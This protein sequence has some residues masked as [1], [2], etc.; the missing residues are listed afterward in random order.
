MNSFVKT[1]DSYGKNFVSLFTAAVELFFLSYFSVKS[2]MLNKA[3]NFRSIISVL[4]AQVYFTGVQ[5]LPL[6]SILA[7]ATGVIFL[8]QGLSH[9][10]LVGGT[11]ILGSFLVASIVREASPILVALVVIA[12]SGTAVATEIGNMKANR[13]IDALIAMGINPYS[14][15]IFPRLFG[16]VVSIICLA[17]YFNVVALAGGLFLATLMRDISFEFFFNSLF[18]ALQ[19]ED[20][21]IFIL[22]NMIGGF[23][24][25][26][27]STRSGFL[28]QK[29]S[30]EVPQRTTQAVV[31]SIL[32]V[33]LVNFMI[34]AFFYAVKL[35]LIS[36]E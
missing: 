1:V 26:T 21:L 2:I 18:L 23:L 10:A 32:S 24:I 19:P 35:K 29:S 27:I 12:R 25:F 8:F 16:G 3:E 31:H 33:T 30:H 13:E 6:I 17:F 5:A 11:Q 28:V 22:K 34:T 15:I 9:F 7:L 14:Y 4:S 20:F 36:M